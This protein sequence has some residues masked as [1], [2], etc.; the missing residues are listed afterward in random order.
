MDQRIFQK[1]E[2]V[3]PAIDQAISHS[4]TLFLCTFNIFSAS[5]P[6]FSFYLLRHEGSHSF[7]EWLPEVIS[8]PHW[9]FFRIP[10]LHLLCGFTFNL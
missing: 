4:R 8:Q 7:D 6:A 1:I 3:I 10:N 9:N 2:E 5:H